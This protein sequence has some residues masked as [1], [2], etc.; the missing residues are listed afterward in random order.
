MELLAEEV[1]HIGAEHGCAV[2]LLPDGLHVQFDST[3]SVPVAELLE[4]LHFYLPD[5]KEEEENDW[6]LAE[7]TLWLEQ[8]LQQE[9]EDAECP[10]PVAELPEHSQDATSVRLLILC[11]LPG[12]GKSS[13]SRRFAQCRLQ[14]P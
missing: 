7:W 13:L 14:R 3:S 5:L 8:M 4:A 10:R 1:S 9:K 11:G 12:A 6:Q 2:W